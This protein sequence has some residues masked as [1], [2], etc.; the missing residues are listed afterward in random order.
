MVTWLE[1]LPQ[2]VSDKILKLCN[3]R[4]IVRM[5]CVCKSWYSL[6]KQNIRKRPP[7][8]WLMM[9]CNSSLENEAEEEARCFFSLSEDTIYS[10]K[11]PEIRG[12]CCCGSFSN[13]NAIGWLMTIDHNMDI[14]LLH[15]WRRIQLQ[16]PHY[17]D[18]FPKDYNTY[19]IRLWPQFA[20][21][22]AAMSDDGAVVAVINE[23][24][25][26]AF[27]RTREDNVWTRISCTFDHFYKFHDVIYHKGQ[28]YVIGND[29]KIGVLCINTPYPFVQ[30]LTEMIEKI[31]ALRSH[32]EYNPQSNY[33]SYLVA[34]SANESL[35]IVSKVIMRVTN[36]HNK[37]GF[38]VFE[39]G[40]EESTGEYKKNVVEVESLG[41]RVMFLGLSS[42][43]LITACQSLGIKGNCIYFT[44]DRLKHSLY[45]LPA[46]ESENMGIFNR[47]DK[48]VRPLFQDRYHPHYSPPIWITPPGLERISL[49]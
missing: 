20:I 9:V 38:E 1:E 40:L 7:L 24:W 14:R 46:D 13:G 47:E 23:P 12:K 2:D 27:C 19:F 6:S 17:S 49:S 5:G 16:L 21:R 28:F 41:D 32:G 15:P 37:Y 30:N 25:K 44:D 45:I 31:A 42:S 4:D 29:G 10:I 43:M 3:L 39:L 22:K 33:R 18:I 8:P 34:D 11:L 35:F 36:S 26:I 48:T